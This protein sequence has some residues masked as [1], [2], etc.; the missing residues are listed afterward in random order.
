MSAHSHASRPPGYGAT[1]LALF[2]LLLL[3]GALVASG[4]FDAGPW[5]TGARVM[6]V[7][8]AVALGYWLLLHPLVRRWLH[9]SPY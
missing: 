1:A 3:D 4:A 5:R 6:L 7:L 9:R 2:G 8:D